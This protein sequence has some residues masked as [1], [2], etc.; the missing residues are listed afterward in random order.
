M[1]RVQTTRVAHLEQ[2]YRLG[3][4]ILITQQP[5]SWKFCF[6]DVCDLAE[7]S[8]LELFENVI[9]LSCTTEYS[10]GLGGWTLKLLGRAAIQNEAIS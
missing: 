2:K 8:Q 7:K 6:A 3:F 4:T 5:T 9:T 1:A 10:L